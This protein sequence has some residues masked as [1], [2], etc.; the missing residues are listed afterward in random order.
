MMEFLVALIPALTDGVRGLINRWTGGAGA[1]PANV[2][3]VIQIQTA[4]TERLKA[5]AKLDKVS[6][7]TSKWVN[8]IRALQRPVA[9]AAILSTYGLVIYFNAGGETIGQVASFAEMAVFYLF[10]ERG[11][12]YMKQGK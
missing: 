6:G 7:T 10:G 5:L 12:R 2:E 4:D 11:Y 3:E 8:N 9:V 1:Q